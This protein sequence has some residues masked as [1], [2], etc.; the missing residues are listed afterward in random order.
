M[1]ETP[2]NGEYYAK[3]DVVWKSPVRTEKPGGSV[4]TIGFP[5]CKM[6]EACDDQAASLAAM[7][8]GRAALRAALEEAI[9][10]MTGAGS[11]HTV[12]FENERKE[13]VERARRALE[14]S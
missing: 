1:A 13:C 2:M 4:V 12:R 10:I 8:N 14:E 9:C 7:L 3:G 11:W 5:V 6:T